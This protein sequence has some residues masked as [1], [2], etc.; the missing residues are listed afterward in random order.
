MR[1]HGVDIGAVEQRLVGGRIVTLDPL[2]QLVLAKIAGGLARTLRL[3]FRRVVEGR[4]EG[5]GDRE[6]VRDR[7]EDLELC[8]RGRQ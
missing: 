4:K 3:P 6:D 1:L 5:F 8:A 7:L 2:D